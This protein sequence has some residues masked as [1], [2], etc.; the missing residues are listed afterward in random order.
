M[1]KANQQEIARTLRLSQPTVSRALANHPSVNAETKAHVWEAAVR[2]GYQQKISQLRKGTRSGRP[3]VAGIVISIPHQH[4]AKSETFQPVLKGLSEKSSVEN[5]LL[6]VLHHEPADTECVSIL[7][8]IKQA[9]WQGCILFHPINEAVVRKIEKTIPCVS[10]IENYRGGFIDC[11]DVDQSEGIFGL[12]RQ[13]VDAGHRR[14]GFFSWVYQVE[15]PWVQ[16]R[17]GSFVEA[18]YR[19]GLTFDERDCINIRPS[20][21]L[22][23]PEAAALAAE[24][25][26]DGVTAF[27]CAAD[28]QA[29]PLIAELGRHGIKV[30][31]DCSLTG[32][33]GLEP[34]AG[35]LQV[36]TVRVPYDE[37]GRSAIGQLLRRAE[38]PTAPRSH[39]LVDGELVPGASVAAPAKRLRSKTA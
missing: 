2:L 9:G 27:C 35:S 24:R 34:P 28:H 6:D 18:L 19:C 32:F 17:L 3:F 37:L 21:A 4:Q 25:I 31:R 8:R 12:A 29:Y 26:R 1:P 10:I 16:R 23:P 33:D 5:I 7:R 20:D 36:A 15:T 11:L 39:L 14:I 38:N 13:L 30:P 22:Q